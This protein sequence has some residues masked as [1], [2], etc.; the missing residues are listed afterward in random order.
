MLEKEQTL[1][2]S[3]HH[4]PF[5]FFVSVSGFRMR[6]KKYNE[7][8]PIN[9]P[10]VHVIGALVCYPQNFIDCRILL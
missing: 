4:S 7:L 5:K 9:T 6:F 10:S 8:Y 1:F 3:I 2:P